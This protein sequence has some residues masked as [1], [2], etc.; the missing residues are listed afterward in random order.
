[1][2]IG[3]IA[4]RILAL[5]GCRGDRIESDVGEEDDGAAGQ[6][7]SPAIGH[8]G[9][10]VVGLDEAGAGKDEDE[11]GGD[12]DQH[13]DVV[14]AGRL[15]DAAHQDHGEDHDDEEGGD[16]E[17]E[18]PAGFVEIVAGKIL[19]AGGQISGRDPHQGW[20]E[21]EPVQQVDDVGGKAHANAHVA[22]GVLKNQIPADDPR[23]E[24]TK[25]SVGVGVGRAC[26]GN[27]RRQLGVAKPGE[28]A[29]DGD[30]HQRERQRRTSAGPACHGGVVK[31]PVQKGRG[32][33]R[34]LIEILA[35]HGR[36]DDRE[37]ARADDRA[38]AE[39]G[40][41]P[42]PKALLERVLGVFR[43]PDELIDRFAGKQ[44]AGQDS[45]P[46]TLGRGSCLRASVTEYS[47]SG[48]GGAGL[49][50]LLAS[51]R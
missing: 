48:R 28:C 33:D 15:A 51:S 9:M 11:N 18:V 21:V 4:L 19:Q 7:A 34:G 2:P 37:N 46:H 38:D 40:Q 5:L 3:H 31:Q 26:D 36:A 47:P 14:G 16:I 45:S 32:A 27:H 29:D 13:H 35:G 22:E 44:L 25:G 50:Q 17:A 23:G 6:Y 10:P 1:M 43:L 41:R 12:L 39:R 49:R 8:E 42:R 30:Q 24:L 20:M